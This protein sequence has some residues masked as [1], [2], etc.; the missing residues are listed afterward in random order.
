[1]AKKL[2]DK[3]LGVVVKVTPTNDHRV[4]EGRVVSSEFERAG[5]AAYLHCRG[6]GSLY[7]ITAQG[8][9]ELEDSF[10]RELPVGGYFE[11]EVCPSCGQTFGE[12][13]MKQVTMH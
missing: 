3:L 2:A 8:K 4:N 10:K 1:M 12:I 13:R 6:C 9:R 5:S 11:A 7:E